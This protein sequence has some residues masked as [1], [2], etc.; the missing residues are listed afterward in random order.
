LA[1]VVEGYL[2]PGWEIDCELDF[3]LGLSKVPSQEAKE[4][5]EVVSAWGSAAAGPEGASAAC[6]EQ[7]VLWRTLLEELRA[8]RK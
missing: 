4:V 1:A 5:T 2:L 8:C 6:I 7:E 3:E